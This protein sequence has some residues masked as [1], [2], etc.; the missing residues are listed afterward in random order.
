MNCWDYSR[1]KCDKVQKFPS[2]P[3]GL[4]RAG[5]V[6]GLAVQGSAPRLAAASAS[7]IEKEAVPF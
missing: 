4:R 1:K 5:R 2:S 3:F 6:Q 7:Q